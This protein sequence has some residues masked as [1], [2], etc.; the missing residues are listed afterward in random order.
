MTSAQFLLDRVTGYPE[1]NASKTLF[2]WV[3]DK[4][5]VTRTLTYQEFDEATTR[6]ASALVDEK[7]WNVRPGA[8]VLL[9]YPPGLDFIIAFVACL[10]AGIVAVP[11]YPPRPGASKD[12]NMFVSVQNSSGA[13]VALTNTQYNFAKRVV[14]F[15]EFFSGKRHR[16]PDIHWLITD[17]SSLPRS[18]PPYHQAVPKPTKDTIAFL[19]Y[20][21]GSTAAP[22]GVVVTHGNLA[23]NLSSIVEALEAGPSTVVVAWLP[24]YHDMGLI[25][26]LLGTVYCGGS[27]VYMSPIS[28]IKNPVL[29]VDLMSKYRATHVQGPNF[30]YK[31]VVR[32]FKE[33]GGDPAS[34]D[35]SSVVH[36]FNAAEP[37]EADAITDFLNTFKPS[38]LKKEAMSPG[39]G[40]AEHTVYV[41]DRGEQCL[42]VNKTEIEVNRR[43]VVVPED[44]KNGDT[45]TIVGCGNPH[46][47]S[48]SNNIQVRI[49][50]TKTM[51]ALDEDHVGEVWIDSPS[52]AAGYFGRDELT[53]EAFFATILDEDN[54]SSEDGRSWLR[55]GD[56][57][58][59]HRGE[60][61]ICG[62]I[63]DLIIIRGRNHYPQD[64][65]HS[66]ENASGKIRPGCVA[67]FTVPDSNGQGEYLGIVAE[68]RD[69][70][71]NLEELSRI[72]RRAVSSEHG[73]LPLVVI[74]VQTH[75][76]PKTTSGKISRF[77]SREAYLAGT[78]SE[79]HR[80]VGNAGKVVEEEAFLSSLEENENATPSGPKPVL[81]GES[82][83]KTGPKLQ[84]AA[85]LETLKEEVA[86]LIEGDPQEIDATLPLIE[87]GMDSMALTQLK[88]V[89]QVSYNTDMEEIELFDQETTLE[90]VQ[91]RVE[92]EPPAAKF[93]VEGGAATTPPANNT[94]LA[95]SEAAK[96]KPKVKKRKQSLFGCFKVCG[97]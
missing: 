63:K 46:R 62:R 34:L 90:T 77:R 45:M 55:S 3:D 83:P 80:Y 27:G 91:R 44:N 65:E 51:R 87:L 33:R 74:L 64:I 7:K 36:M 86:R 5:K 16:W 31:L 57:G 6:L 30:A 28:F 70:N 50:D 52:K 8:T 18:S 1:S 14:A 88:G 69:S 40:L 29:W 85:L 9:V 2:T 66:V 49:V 97:C 35:L 26:S 89:L 81:I 76:I 48:D 32:K 58:F 59:M 94:A 93:L 12:L 13:S 38:K 68:V 43:V 53:K 22:K 60:L 61:F 79:V 71:G 20:T 24:C 56:L 41:C 23:H 15:K 92:G 21:S 95:P 42:I 19:Q 96:P 72:I 78:L 73:V 54:K 25:G 39:Y 11:V 82:D 17:D 47:H 84:G 37:I 4:G 75:S 10:K 67:A